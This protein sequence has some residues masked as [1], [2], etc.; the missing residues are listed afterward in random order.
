MGY[1]KIS[2]LCAAS[3][4][5][6]SGQD[7][8]LT[9]ASHEDELLGKISE[10]EKSLAAL[11]TQKIQ[12]VDLKKS[13]SD[14]LDLLRASRAHGHKHGAV[15]PYPRSVGFSLFFLISVSL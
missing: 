1:R 4:D 11:S 2:Q 6:T 14:E 15:H 9:I 8:A 13:I 5:L 3:A 12:L 10:I 7:H